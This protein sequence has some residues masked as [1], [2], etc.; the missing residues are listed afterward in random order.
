M[1]AVLPEYYLLEPLKRAKNYAK[2]S[3]GRE[4]KNLTDLMQSVF[5]LSDMLKPEK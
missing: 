3:E 4:E 5:S 1:A 2:G